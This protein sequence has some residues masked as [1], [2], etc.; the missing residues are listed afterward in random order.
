MTS[1]PFVNLR[2]QYDSLKEEL[3]A[4]ALRVLSSGR[5]VQ[6]PEVAAFEEEF[7]RYCETPH[8]VAVNSGTSAL[9]LALL[10]AGVGP[11]DEVITVPLTFIATVSAIH[12]AGARPVFVDVDPATCTLAVGQ[13]E[14]AVTERTRAVVPVHLYG[15]PADMDPL[16]ALARRYSLTVIEDACQA[17]GALYKGRRVGGIGHLGCFSFYP[18]KNL[19]ACGEGGAVLTRD[20]DLAAKLRQLR[21]WGQREKYQHL[22]KGFNY[23]MSELQA[24]GLRVKLRRLDS[25]NED[26]RRSAGLYRR[27]LG[28][29]SG[30][31][32]FEAMSYAH[33]V[34]HI[35][36]LRT[37]FRE[38]VRQSLMEGG[39]ETGVHYPVPVHLTPAFAELGHSAGSFPIS[40]RIAEEELSLPM[41]PELRED[42]VRLVA[43]A[44][45][46]ALS[47]V[48]PG[49]A[50]SGLGCERPLASQSGRSPRGK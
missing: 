16:L 13:V 22:S 5:Y 4:A 29:Q 38:E 32:L 23:R 14:A 6:G 47:R 15:Q 41:Y 2:A 39:V 7:A 9:H 27:L 45:K 11:G 50:S 42:E 26:R 33:P 3:D 44:L 31:S 20:P 21:D 12:Y 49:E 19:G 10:A 24:A 37:S 48:G 17:H 34:Y 43:D 8:A 1:I 35:F 28:N 25:W 40:E 36:A 46:S 18:T 30:A